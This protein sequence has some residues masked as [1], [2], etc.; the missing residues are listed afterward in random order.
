MQILPEEPRTAMPQVRNNRL[1]TDW[2]PQSSREKN[3]TK[4]ELS[5]KPWK[6][7][8]PKM[9]RISSYWTRGLSGAILASQDFLSLDRF[10]SLYC[11]V[12]ICKSCNNS[13]K[14]MP[15]NHFQYVSYY[16]TNKFTKHLSRELNIHEHMAKIWCK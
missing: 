16:S 13:T 5:E 7:T 12:I 8:L 9:T 14:W 2:H 1:Y 6:L 10:M 4:I 11:R 3:E 15:K